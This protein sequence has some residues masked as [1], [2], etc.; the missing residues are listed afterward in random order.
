[1]LIGMTKKS[2]KRLINRLLGTK[3]RSTANRKPRRKQIFSIGIYAGQSPVQLNPLLEPDHPVLTRE[4]VSDVRAGFVADPFM[5]KVDGTWNMFFEVMNLE[6]KNGE[7]GLATSQDA[8]QW[9]YQ[10]IILREPFHLSYPYVFEWKNE[11][12]M[13]PEAYRTKSVRLYKAVNFPARWSFVTT[14]LEGDDFVDPSIFYFNQR[15][16]LLS[17]LHRAPFFAGTLRLFTSDHLEGGWTEHPQ[18][19]VLEGSPHIA[20]PGGRVVTWNGKLVRYT[21]DCCPNY[22][23]QVRAF[24]I[25]E[26]TPKTYRDQV[27]DVAPVVS[28]SGAGWNESGMHHVDPHKDGSRWIACVDGFYWEEL[29]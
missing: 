23:T 25:T 17:D 22:G 9:S 6:T 2:V 29:R 11:H 13:I 1:M 15:W 26:C 7:I 24:E 18:S 8:R 12:Y 21:Q 4:S 28:P 16:W 5:L 20:R 19:P 14:L 27:V 3:S 10:K